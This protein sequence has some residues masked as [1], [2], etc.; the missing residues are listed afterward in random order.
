MSEETVFQSNQEQKPSPTPPVAPRV[1]VPQAPSQGGSYKEYTRSG[2]PL[3]LGA[4][5][6]TMIKLI[7]FGLLLIIVAF[8]AYRFITPLF[9]KKDEA[10]TISYWGLWEDNKTMQGIIEEFQKEHPTI[11]VVYT[12]SDIKQY[13]ERLLART[14]SGKGPDVFRFHNTWLLQLKSLLLPLPKEV[15]TKEELQ[16]MYYPVVQQDVI[17]NGAIYGIPLEVDT[18]ALFT[19]KDIFDAAGV[20]V[21]TNWNDFDSV[22]RT[23]TVK[24]GEGNIKTAGAAMGTFDN[25]S[26]ASDIISLLFAQNGAETRNL[27]GTLQDASDALDF[28]TSF[29][30]GDGKV[31][32]ETQDMSL[33]SFA[34]GNLAMY[35]GYSWD[36]FLLQAVNPN[37]S[38][39]VYPVPY[40]PDRK[41]TIASYWVEGVSTASRNQKEALLF[42]QFLTSRETVQKLFTEQAKTRSFGEP[43]ARVDLAETA[44]DNSLLYPFVS[45]AP[46]AV[47]TFFASDTFDNGFN[48]QMNGYLGNA[49]R[50]V[51]GNT[52]S[53]TAVEILSQG[54]SKV[55][56]QYEANK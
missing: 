29:A 45:Q 15:I 36:I 51:L 26:H 32:D 39:A 9:M 40:L 53:Q 31:W 12:K 34:K 48:A 33:F 13:R 50:S 7:V 25:I 1:L 46:N 28:Y 38:F 4:N 47:S 21:P 8:V 27:S 23:L 35:F 49:A 14:E 42:L 17:L 10:V 54:I 18:L 56:E 30:K 44:K 2:P 20:S 37:L 24:D 16:S 6:L 22:A 52:S 11:Q 5:F 3:V 55:L 43:Y 19:N 41:M